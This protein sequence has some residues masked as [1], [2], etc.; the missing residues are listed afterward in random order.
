MQ[1]MTILI[2]GA[3]SA[4]AE[5]AAREWAQKGAK[6]MLTARDGDRLEMV[7][8]DLRLRGA[9][10]DTCVLDLAEADIEKVFAQ[11]VEQMGRVDVVLL[12]YGLLGN[13]QEAEKDANAAQT[14]LHVNFTSAAQWCL[15]SANWLEQ[16]NHGC[17][18]VIGS[19]AGDRGRM[20][21]YIYG[22]AKGGLDILVNGIAHRLAKGSARA[23]LIKPGFV[24]TP[25]TAAFSKGPLW[26]KPQ[27]IARVIVNAAEKCTGPVIYAPRFW[28]PIMFIIR[29]LPWLL[30]RK[31]SL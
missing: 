31:T 10:V 8:T 7:A 13:Q 21:N 12:A 14:M 4:M 1:G 16:Q 11:I 20:S 27:T 9:T 23:V 19:V 24:D 22:A 30:F 5:A 28:R 17:L 15:V 25:M 26:A 6:L 2:L 18:I 29:S 3:L